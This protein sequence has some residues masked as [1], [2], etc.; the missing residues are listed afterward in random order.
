MPKQQQQQIKMMGELRF[1][2]RSAH[3]SAAKKMMEM[4]F[5]VSR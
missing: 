4:L 5:P 1:E 2:M 3:V